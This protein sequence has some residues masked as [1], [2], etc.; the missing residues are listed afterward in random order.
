MPAPLAIDGLVPF[1]R[2]DRAKERLAGLL[3]PD[4]REALARLLL[5]EAL[6]ALAG[7]PSIRRTYLVTS[8]RDAAGIAAGYGAETVAE[9]EGVR[10]LNPALEA[11]RTA[12]LRTANPPAA[13]LI[14]HADIAG[15][16]ARAIE[17]FVDRAGGEPLVRLC[18]AR[19]DGTNALLLRP[20]GVIPFRYG[21]R[22]APAHEAEAQAAGAACERRIVAALQD[23][24]DTPADVERL[25]RSGRGGAAVALLRSF[26][27]ADRV[28]GAG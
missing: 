26:G 3:S 19:D 28:R 16:D 4:E 5:S 11:A 27:V 9:P 20:P 24:L 15:L 8:D 10:G 23:D 25:L 6:Q 13:L 22:S 2:F 7:A 1:K 14:L 18:A 21:P 12:I 17:W